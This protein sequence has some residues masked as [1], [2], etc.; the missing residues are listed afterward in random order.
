MLFLQSETLKAEID[1][2]GAALRSLVVINA[3]G[4]GT[5]VVATGPA[6]RYGGAT[7]G[8]Y[9]NRIANARFTLDG[10]AYALAANEGP[11][12]LHG[13]PRGFDAVPWHTAQA[14]RDSVSLELVSGDGDQ[15]FPGELRVRVRFRVAHG[16]LSIEYAAL[17]DRDTVINLTN[18]SYFN[19]S[20]GAVPATDH[21][22]RIDAG[23]YTP[24]DEALIPTGAIAGV[25][26]T[27]YDFRV[28]KII[29]SE[30]FDTNW[31]LASRSAACAT[32]TCD[33]SPWQLD[34][35]TSEPGLQMYS[36]NAEG[37]A[38]ETQHFPD[39]PN[40]P[41]FPS[42]TLRAGQMFSSNTIYRFTHR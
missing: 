2:L 41:Q 42:T 6:M 12:Q 16:E 24:V 29:E 8:R 7:I 1:P 34:I 21:L 40:Q 10:I 22:L 23:A 15:G 27:R 11:N 30:S 28:A 32:L 17:C 36:G 4:R 39:S 5:E 31:V 14:G 3:S 25:A 20:G 38:L 9:A 13:G 35:R 33:A 19:L 37:I 18:H 26:G